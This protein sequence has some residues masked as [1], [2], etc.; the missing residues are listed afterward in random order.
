MEAGRLTEARVELDE[1]TMSLL[2][3]KL[4]EIRE[5]GKNL[6]EVT[7]TWFQEDA[8]KEGG[9]YST[10]TDAVRKIDDDR[11]GLIMANGL[12]IPIECIRWIEL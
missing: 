11:R 6:P 1:D 10:V 7:V 3:A 9:H 8:R 5:N 4:H 2:D 12:E